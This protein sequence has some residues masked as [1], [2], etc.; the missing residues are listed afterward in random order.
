MTL[1]LIQ[2]LSGS[3]KTEHYN[4]H[5]VRI[6]CRTVVLDYNTFTKL[7]MMHWK[8]K[9]LSGRHHHTQTQQ[10]EELCYQYCFTQIS[11]LIPEATWCH[12]SVVVFFTMLK[13]LKVCGNDD[14]D[15]DDDD[16]GCKTD[17]GSGQLSKSTKAIYQLSQGS[18]NNSFTF[19]RVIRLPLGE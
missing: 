4:L 8:H 15:D 10:I 12:W 17:G 6:Y 5:E 16:D 9:K 2:C 13:V 19:G 7:D 11:Q 14:D 3:T 1:H 18:Q